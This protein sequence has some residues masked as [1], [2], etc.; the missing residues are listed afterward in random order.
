[1]PC[2]FMAKKYGV[3]DTGEES[4]VITESPSM[5]ERKLHELLSNI[6][7]YS[8]VCCMCLREH[9]VLYMMHGLPAEFHLQNPTCGI[10]D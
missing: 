2:V 4:I 7:K 8:G 10:L 3:M 1:M 9:E 5:L 6:F